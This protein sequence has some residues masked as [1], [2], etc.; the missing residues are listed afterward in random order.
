MEGC[1][2][3]KYRWK[4]LAVAVMVLGCLP[5][6]ASAGGK[7]LRFILDDGR[8]VK[9]ELLSVR[10]GS[11]MV[12]LHGGRTEEE[13]RRFPDVVT[14]VPFGKVESVE[15]PGR[16]N[17]LTGMFLGL[18]GGSLIGGLIGSAAADDSPSGW[19]DWN[20][21]MSGMAG[22]MVGSLIGLGAGTVVG[23]ATSVEDEI[24]APEDLPNAEYFKQYAR[25]KNEEPDYLR[26]IL[27]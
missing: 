7:E 9:G 13:L 1:D 3:M 17:L 11:F 14:E 26:A 4:Q 23:L 20:E 19:E 15:I 10:S 16:S 21:T 22:A 8:E 5:A 18:A 12:A 2:S 27:R 25:Y 6:N 24:I